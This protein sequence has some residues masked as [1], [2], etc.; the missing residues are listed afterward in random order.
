MAE[1]DR[2]ILYPSINSQEFPM[3]NSA[4]T[5]RTTVHLGSMTP[6]GMIMAVAIGT[7]WMFLQEQAR[8]EP[9]F[10]T[11][12]DVVCY[13]FNGQAVARRDLCKMEDFDTSSVITWSDGVQTRI[14]WIARSR[15]I[16]ALDGVDAVKYFRNP[17]SLE[18]IEQGVHRSP[19][20]CL[21]AI[22]SDNSVCW[23]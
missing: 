6:I 5:T 14:R 1:P 13:H 11:T 2:P 23:R 7:G 10:S 17:D 21:Q 20:Q 16:P 4:K 15:E 3:T 18:V 8:A 22:G 19:I 9:P 12:T